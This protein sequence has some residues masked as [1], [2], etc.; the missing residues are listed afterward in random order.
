MAAVLFVCT[1]NICRSPTAHWALKAAIAN[2]G[3]LAKTIV[4]SAGTHGYHVGDPADERAVQVA[5]A[6]GIDMA[7]HAARSVTQDDFQKFDL[8]V[9]L[10]QGHYATLEKMMPPNAA[11]KLI[12]FM[13]F[14]GHPNTD[15]ADPYYGDIGDFEEMFSD[16]QKGVENIFQY[17]ADY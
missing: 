12:L 2:H 8:I 14:V 5:E 4:D 16:I 3:K 9:A 6:H 11:A 1:G 17:L 15:I 13:D 7:G 10:D